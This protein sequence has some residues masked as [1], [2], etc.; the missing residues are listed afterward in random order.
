METSWEQISFIYQCYHTVI[1]FHVYLEVKSCSW[2]CISIFIFCYNEKLCSILKYTSLVYRIKNSSIVTVV[3]YCN[4]SN[5][6]YILIIL[7]TILI[8]VIVLYC[9][10]SFFVLALNIVIL[11]GVFFFICFPLFIW[12]EFHKET[13]FVFKKCIESFFVITF[14]YK[15]LY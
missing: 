1:E 14:C 5:F 11:D 10:S 2:V 4:S 13:P 3:L 12:W 6:S 9:N 15:S 7:I 8:I